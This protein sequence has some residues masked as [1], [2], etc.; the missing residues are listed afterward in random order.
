MPCFIQ[1]NGINIRRE[2]WEHPFNAYSVRDLAN[3]KA[4]RSP[5]SLLLDHVTLEGLDPFLVSFYDL[6]IHSDIITWLEGRKLLLTTHL[7]MYIGDRVHNDAF[8]GWQS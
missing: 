2:K 4:G 7:L 5:V 1:H 3:R 6:I 8:K